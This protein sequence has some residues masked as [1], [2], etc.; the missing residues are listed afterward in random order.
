MH[1]LR[2]GEERVNLETAKKEAKT[3]K[4][5]ARIENFVGILSLF[6]ASIMA[7]TCIGLVYWAIAPAFYER[8]EIAWLIAIGC[9]LSTAIC[10]HLLLEHL[11]RV[12]NHFQ[13]KAFVVMC[14]LTMLTLCIGGSIFLG[15]ARSL[16][17]ELQQHLEGDSALELETKHETPV[18]IEK[19]KNEI[20]KLTS[21]AL[22]LMA[23]T[24]D[25]V[26]AMLLFI[27]TR[28]IQQNREVVDHS[29][30][31]R[32]LDKHIH[33]LEKRIAYLES[34]TMDAV[35]NGIVAGYKKSKTKGSRAILI[36]VSLAFIASIIV[37][38]LMS[39]N[40][41]F[42]K[43]PSTHVLCCLDVTGSAERER[44]EN[45]RAVLRIIDGLKPGDTIDV[46]LITE[47]TFNDPEYLI[48]A[49]MPSKSGYFKE[50]V[51]KAKK[52]LIR[53]FRKKAETLSESRCATSIIDGLYLF[54]ELVKEKPAERHVLVLLSD[55]IQTAQGIKPETLAR[56]GG[57]V[58]NNLKADSL[59]PDMRGVE[60]YVMG[61]ST[62]GMNLKT[63]TKLKH[64]WLK[65]FAYAGANMK[66][67]SIGRGAIE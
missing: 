65:Y 2:Q 41:A 25:V 15:K 45:T 14:S 62:N 35:K 11:Q 8:E 42:A 6:F 57:K 58:L 48:S 49:K 60:V 18:D 61:A 56:D 13:F 53:E 22:I 30:K 63:W 28:K 7:V 38:L 4:A 31:L 32:S 64:F 50:H 19:L 26:A 43:E 39:E 47:K 1:K 54:A 51:V 21:R 55:M 37:F 36:I 34:V 44:I 59:I 27:G 40:V 10:G 23:I 33:K 67:Y 66:A 12:L 46:M 20:E 52:G 5:K 24:L 29:K 16:Q 17:W 9:G 3:S